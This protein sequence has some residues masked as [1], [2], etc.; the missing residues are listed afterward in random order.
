[1]QHQYPL[2][3]LD[4]TITLTLNPEK[5][6]L[7][8][9]TPEEINACLVRV[10]EENIQLQSL[11]NNQVFAIAER[12]QIEQLIRQY[13]SSLTLLL[14]QALKNEKDNLFKNESLKIVSKELLTCLDE[15]LCFV[16]DRFSAYLSLDERVPA[17]YLC[18][19]KRDLQKRLKKIEPILM[20]FPNGEEIFLML[21]KRLNT[22]AH[23][24]NMH[25][26]ITIRNILYEKEL[27]RSLERL[28]NHS[29]N[30]S[31]YS[32]LDELLIYLNFNSKG[33]INRFTQKLADKINACEDPVESMEQLLLHYKVFNQ[34]H[35]KPEV[36]LNPNYHSLDTVLGNWFEQEIIYLKKKMHRSVIP[37]HTTSETSKLKKSPEKEKQKVMCLISADQIALILRAAGDVKIVFAKSMNE[38]FKTIIPHLS[39]PYTEDLSFDAVRSKSYVA[40]ERDKEIAIETLELIIKQIKGY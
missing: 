24:D 14:D 4:S 36:I 34:M 27:I 11:I 1:M 6:D 19:S 7:S 31:E 38:L 25:F 2:E 3:W 23:F 8:A 20:E 15:L 33:Y 5:T 32:A 35:R 28:N 37:L 13:H 17:L 26:E 22:L 30:L 18:V 16:E 9:I 39:T 10:K 40:E 12:N 29:Q 21:T